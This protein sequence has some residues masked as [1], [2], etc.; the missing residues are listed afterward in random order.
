MKLSHLVIL[1]IVFS[2]C[3]A[4]F[5]TEPIMQCVECM[6]GKTW[7]DQPCCDDDF[8]SKC[9]DKD[10]VV[11]SR[12][13]HPVFTYLNA[14]FKKAPDA[15][16]ACATN[17]ECM[18]GLCDLQSPINNNV[19]TLIEREERGKSFGRDLYT[20]KY[21]CPSSSPG[22]CAEAVA[23]LG[24]PG[25]SSRSLKMEGNILIDNVSSGPIF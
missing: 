25:G 13:L 21:S 17:K 12:D 3:A 20:A 10:G 6:D 19:C 11:R 18:S 8:A 24:N 1:P 23:S 14:C 22:I 15:G 9:E 7:D 5:S 4:N 2:G 16:N